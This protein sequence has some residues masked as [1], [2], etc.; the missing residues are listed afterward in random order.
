MDLTTPAI[1][2]TACSLPY[3][4]ALGRTGFSGF[5]SP[6]QD[7]EMRR[8]DLNQRLVKQPAATFYLSVTGDSM[9]AL[10]IQANDLLIVDRSIPPR[11]GHIL[12]AMV[13]GEIVVKRYETRRGQPFLCSSNPRYPPIPL[14]DSDCQVWGVVRAVIHEYPL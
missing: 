1:P 8:L 3:P 10:G 14:E 5:P 9:E 13:E 6:S 2:A 7:Y 4:I 12:V 11:P